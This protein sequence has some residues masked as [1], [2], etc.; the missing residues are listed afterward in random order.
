[1]RARVQISTD[2]ARAALLLSR[3]YLRDEDAARAAVSLLENAEALIALSVEMFSLP[4]VA[5]HL[6]HLRP[7]WFDP[8]VTKP[9][10][11]QFAIGQMTLRAEQREFFEK[12]L[13][14]DG[15]EY[16]FIKGIA[17]A[18]QF[19][20]RPG[21]RFARD[22]D[23]LVKRQT[24]V[25]I[26]E[27]ALTEGY[28]L[29][30]T[31]DYSKTLSD[32]QDIRAAHRYQQVFNLVSPKGRHIEVHLEV[33]KEQGIFDERQLLFK[34]HQID[35]DGRSLKT[36]NPI[37][38]FLYVAY[39]CAR[40]N[41]SRLHWLADL[42]AMERS[43]L[44]D[45]RRLMERATEMGLGRL[46]DETLGFV[47]LSADPSSASPDAPGAR[48]LDRALYILKHGEHKAVEF[49]NSQASTAL[50]FPDMLSPWLLRKV[51]VKRLWGRLKPHMSDYQSWPL[52]DHWQWV[53]WVAGPTRRVLRKRLS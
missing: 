44:V 19:Y 23:V 9:I 50:P 11:M 16:A 45:R 14:P 51:R 52:P 5:K 41:W 53:Y 33:D 12:C 34:S 49:A 36:L 25:E 35:I 29:L 8:S 32:R 31:V 37:D 4:M 43:P 26:V 28:T 2:V 46:M 40:H 47:A 24:A 38:H 7:D 18:D 22:I 13:K 3:E 10:E 42:A 1:M 21:I 15:H 30:D 20:D 48:I 6:N 39:H 17:L 27:R